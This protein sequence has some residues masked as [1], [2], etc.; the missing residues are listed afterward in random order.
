MPHLI[1]IAGFSSSGKTTI[2]R[3]LTEHFSATIFQL[4]TYYF[5]LPH[6]SYEERCR[7]NF[8]HPDSLDAAMIEEHLRELAAGREI[9]R[10]V[11]DFATHSRATHTEQ[12]QPND[13]ILVEGL[14]TLYWERIRPLYAAKIFLEASHQICLPRREMRDLVERGRSLESI[15]R[16]YEE[17]VRQMA[18]QF[19]A[20][21]R[22]FADL[23]LSGKDPVDE[24]VAA[25]LRHLDSAGRRG[26]GTPFSS[27][28]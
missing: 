27:S 23:V 20:P 4:D 13:Y 8:D 16:Q 2:A 12:M 21:T 28:T 22:K 6:L 11:Y 9:V 17:T 18:D 5:D 1:A 10:P 14:Y 25:I 7:I 19:I 15:R 26:N 24:N 3:R